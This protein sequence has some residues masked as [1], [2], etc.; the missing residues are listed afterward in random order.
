MRWHATNRR[1]RTPTIQPRFEAAY[2][3]LLA[4]VGIVSFADLQQRSENVKRLLPR[5]R[6]VAEAMIA[7]NPQVQP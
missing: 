7:A 6:Q 2:R 4:D 3:E 1:R 5:L